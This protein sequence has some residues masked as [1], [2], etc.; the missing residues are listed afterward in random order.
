MC[1]SIPPV[2]A[3]DL[4]KSWHHWYTL[5]KYF[6]ERARSY[7]QTFVCTLPLY[8]TILSH[9]TGIQLSTVQG[10]VLHR[11]R[12][13]HPRNTSQLSWLHQSPRKPTNN[14]CVALYIANMIFLYVAKWNLYME[15]FRGVKLQKHCSFFFHVVVP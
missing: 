1:E 12:L 8:N 4:I 15:I 13:V 10:V 3:G 7:V 6:S 5:S 11:L 14:Y 9:I 2:Y